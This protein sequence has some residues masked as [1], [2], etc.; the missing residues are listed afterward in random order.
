LLWRRGS[1]CNL[2]GANL[3]CWSAAWPLAAREAICA[4]VEAIAAA[5][6]GAEPPA[7]LLATARSL[8][9]RWQQEI[10]SR[11]VDPDRARA[12]DQQFA[13]AF[14][15]IINRW[16]AV[17]GGSDMDPESN[18]RRMETLVGKV[19]ALAASLAGPSGAGVDANVSQTTR[20][21]A[22]LKEAL[23]ANTIGGKADE[24]SRVRA[25]QEELRQAQAQFSRIGL[26]PDDARRQLADRFQRAARKISDRANPRP[27][28]S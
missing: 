27:T 26:V 25:A 21:A 13:L 12:L 24:D 9:S 17:F 28:R 1:E 3:L 8:R 11:G 7:D 16:P 19:E 2:I 22:M 5:P 10:A 6:D 14:G 15:T 18:R 4:E 20:L 23:A